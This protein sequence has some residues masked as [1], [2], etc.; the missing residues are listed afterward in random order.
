M[1]CDVGWELVLQRRRRRTA[2]ETAALPARTH[3]RRHGAGWG[4]RRGPGQ[5]RFAGSSLLRVSS[6]SVSSDSSNWN[7]FFGDP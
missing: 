5:A 4:A 1:S 6:E 3:S 7:L 2:V